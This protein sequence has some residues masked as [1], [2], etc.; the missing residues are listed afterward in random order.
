MSGRK[1]KTV[2]IGI[3]GTTLDAPRRDRWGQWRP[4]VSL[5]MHEDLIV[6]RLELLRGHGS[7]KLADAVA[8][9]VRHV[10]PETTVVQHAVDLSSPWSFPDI[11][12][13]LLDFAKGYPF[14]PEREDYLVHITTGSHVMQI[15]FFLLVESRIVPGRLIQ[16]GPGKQGGTPTY[17]LIDL[18]LERYD[19][20]KERFQRER[21]ESLSFLKAGIA[22]K[23][24]PFNAMIE[25]IE[26]VAVRSRDPILL[27]GPTGAGKSHLA[28]RIYQLRK[29]R[30]ALDGAWV[31]VNCAT[32]RGEHAMAALFGHKKGSF[33][34]AMS[35]RPGLLKQAHKGMLFLDEIGELGDD[36]QAML[37]HAIEDK[38]FLPLGADTPVQVD[39]QLIAGTNRD[40]RDAAREG[41]FREDLLVRL[42]LWTFTLPSLAERREDIEPNLDFELE[43][44]SERHGRAI[45]INA[46]ARKKLLRFAASS[47]AT[48]QG[49]FRDLSAAVTRMATLAPASRIDV[50]TVD[51]EITRLK[52]AWS[53]TDPRAGERGQRIERVLGEAAGELDRFDRVQL[54]DVLSVCERASSLSDAGRTLF[55]QSRARKTSS[56]D[57]DRLKKYLARFE[58]TFA[59]VRAALAP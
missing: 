3:L 35:D 10:S 52:R 54:E 8:D 15:C 11:Y 38:R 33:T 28:R 53:H 31:E 42:D 22:T 32:L 7:E 17:D 41:R 57:A 5:G 25:R 44:V 59:E 12:A 27:M 34:G 37:L 40:L 29:E 14:D 36:E 9:D 23:S 2:V 19:V 49:N 18:D 58:V 43:Q 4:T 39:F 45:T 6:D 51:D 24:A 16:T 47:E 30:G 50:A 20:L 13:T 21:D 26:T 1:R 46:D 48:W 56:N 55:A